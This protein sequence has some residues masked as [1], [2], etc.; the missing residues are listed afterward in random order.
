VHFVFPEQ[1]M[2]CHIAC[3]F[4]CCFWCLNFV[5]GRIKKHVTGL[6]TGVVILIEVKEDHN[7]ASVAARHSIIGKIQI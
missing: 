7:Q 3:R 1:Q 5:L 4:K 2:L 6:G